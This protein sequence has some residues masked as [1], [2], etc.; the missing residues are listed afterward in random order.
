[1]AKEIGSNQSFYQVINRWKNEVPTSN[2]SFIWQLKEKVCLQKVI[3]GTSYILHP[4]KM[5]TAWEYR[6]I[7]H[8]LE[9][10]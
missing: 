7:R 6:V 9:V 2:W 4:H 8:M 5:S 10:S 3:T 1:M